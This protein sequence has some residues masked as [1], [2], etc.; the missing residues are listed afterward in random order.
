VYICTYI[1]YK[2][3]ATLSLFLY[4][5]LGVFFILLLELNYG[6]DMQS[7]A[8]VLFGSLEKL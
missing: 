3:V 4:V 6:Q 5:A 2:G 8:K 1:T 7:L